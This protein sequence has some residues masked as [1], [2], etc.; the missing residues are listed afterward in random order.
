MMQSARD[1]TTARES[2]PERPNARPSERDGERNESAPSATANEPKE[3]RG[4][5]SLG[6]NVE[7]TSP[8]KPESGKSA[9]HAD[10]VDSWGSLPEHVRD[11]FRTQGGGDMP[12][13]YRV[14]IDAYYKRLNKER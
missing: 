11:V 8:G 9:A 3:N 13:Q 5:P 14:W 1:A 4:H 7:S 6:R 12:A 10:A 2:T